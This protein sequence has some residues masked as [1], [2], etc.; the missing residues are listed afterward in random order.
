MHIIGS[1]RNLVTAH[2]LKQLVQRS[3]HAHHVL[4]D[5]SQQRD[6]TDQRAPYVS[7]LKHEL[8]N[9][10]IMTYQHQARAEAAALAQ[11]QQAAAERISSAAA[12]ER[13]GGAPSAARWWSHTPS[14][15]GGRGVD[16]G[17]GDASPGLLQM[18]VR[19]RMAPQATLLLREREFAFE[20]QP[21]RLKHAL[22][23]ALECG[24]ARF[25]SCLLYTSPS[26]R[27]S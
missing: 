7:A 2:S 23:A 12:A 13:I 18:L 27:D 4:G 11:Q 9:M 6:G 26:P 14:V 20:R 5:G 17:G 1:H 8:L 25:M 10:L 21:A 22:Q 16:G 3:R 15:V 24:D 19:W